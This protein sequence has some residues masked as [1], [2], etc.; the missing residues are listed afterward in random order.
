MREEPP[1]ATITTNL[2]V[3][4]QDFDTNLFTGI[5]GRAPIEIWHAKARGVRGNPRFNQIEW[6]YELEKRP[7]WSIDSA[8]REMLGIFE[9]NRDKIVSFCREFNCCLHLLIGLH[10]DETAIIYEIERRTIEWLAAFG[11]S[12]S[13]YV[14]L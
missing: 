14:D 10:G 2:S 13:F 6:S 8:I 4:G 1:V 12:I 9:P 3:G 11:C 7:H 5:A